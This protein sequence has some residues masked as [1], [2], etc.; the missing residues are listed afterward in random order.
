MARRVRFVFVRL[1]LV[2]QRIPLGNNC[3][4]RERGAKKSAESLG[5]AFSPLGT[6]RVK[7]NIGPV[8]LKVVGPR[9]GYGHPRI[10]LSPF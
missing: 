8:C 3:S 4:K 6:F 9:E 7:K 2:L 5:F 10:N 1:F